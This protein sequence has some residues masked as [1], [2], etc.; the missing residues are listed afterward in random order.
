MTHINGISEVRS[1]FFR[2][3]TPC[4]NVCASP[5]TLL[6]MDEFVRGFRFIS[7]ADCFDDAHPRT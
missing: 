2:D 4:Y 6:G 3:P 1:H 7:Y 5:Y